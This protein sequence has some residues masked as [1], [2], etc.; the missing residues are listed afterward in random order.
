MGADQ[1]VAEPS[2]AMVR[3]VAVEAAGRRLG[4]GPDSHEFHDASSE[5]SVAAETIIMC[6]NTVARYITGTRTH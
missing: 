2:Q 3:L 1:Y 6:A 5:A 4:R